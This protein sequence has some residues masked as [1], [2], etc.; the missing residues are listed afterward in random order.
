V[1]DADDP[2]WDQFYDSPQPPP[3]TAGGGLPPRGRDRGARSVV[4]GKRCLPPRA[5]GATARSTAR[6]PR[7]TRVTK[8][9]AAFAA[10][11]AVLVLALTVADAQKRKREEQLRRAVAHL[12]L[13]ASVAWHEVEDGRVYIGFRPAHDAAQQMVDQ[14]LT[15]ELIAQIAAIRGSRAIGSEVRAWGALAA[16]RGWRPGDPAA[17]VVAHTA[18]DGYLVE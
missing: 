12:D 6:P 18:R 11:V 10:L 7:A 8:I 17:R 1:I 15:P 14:L 13:I 2:Q 4:R 16:P 5:D 9:G 3:A